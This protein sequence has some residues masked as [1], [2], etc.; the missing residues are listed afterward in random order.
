M[1]SLRNVQAIKLFFNY[2]KILK[3]TNRRERGNFA[4]LLICN[5]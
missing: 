5:N 1:K 3:Q 2:I 4:E